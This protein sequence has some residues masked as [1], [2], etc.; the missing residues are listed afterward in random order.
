MGT[1][2]G[3]QTSQRPYPGAKESRIAERIIPVKKSPSGTATT[4]TVLT[5]SAVR[6]ARPGA[7]DCYV[8]KDSRCEARAP[9]RIQVFDSQFYQLADH[10]LLEHWSV[11]RG[12]AAFRSQSPVLMM[13]SV[14]RGR[15]HTLFRI[16]SEMPTNWR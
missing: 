10:L 16:S 11:V 8:L 3:E 9:P 12:G 14:S 7:Q 15:T 4:L 5:T 6:S 2:Q 13:P 1:V